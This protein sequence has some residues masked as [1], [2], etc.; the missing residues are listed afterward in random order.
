MSVNLKDSTINPII[1]NVL[2]TLLLLCFSSGAIFAANQRALTE[3]IFKNDT[4]N[5]V[6]NVE[7]LIKTRDDANQVLK[8]AIDQMYEQKNG[9]DSFCALSKQV[10]LVR[11]ALAKGANFS[12]IYI[13]KL[14]NLPSI[15]LAKIM[16]ENP[17]DPSNTFDK[18]KFISLITAVNCKRYNST[19]GSFDKNDDNSLL[20]QRNKLL[21]L[22]L[23]DKNSANKLLYIAINDLYETTKSIDLV[24]LAL[25]KGA[26]FSAVEGEVNW[27]SLPSIELAKIMLENPADPKNTLNKVKFMIAAVDCEQYNSAIDSLKKNDDNGLLE[28]KI[29]LLE[30]VLDN[31]D[32]ANELLKIAI[33]DSY[34]TPKSTALVKL[35]L[36]KGAQFSAVDKIYWNSLPSI[37]LVK[38]VL[39]NP[40]DPKNTI[41]PSKFLSLIVAISSLKRDNATGEY[42]IN[43]D[44]R[45]QKVELMAMALSKGAILDESSYDKDISFIRRSLAHKIYNFF[46][47]ETFSKGED[48]KWLDRCTHEVLGNA[49]EQIAKLHIISALIKNEILNSNNVRL[50]NNKII[51]AEPYMNLPDSTLETNEPYD[52]INSN[53]LSISA[54][55]FAYPYNNYTISHATDLI[56]WLDNLWDDNKILELVK[57]SGVDNHEAVFITLKLRYKAL[58]QLLSEP[59]KTKLYQFDIEKYKKQLQQ[60]QNLTRDFTKTISYINQPEGSLPKI[61]Q[62]SEQMVLYYNESKAWLELNNYEFLLNGKESKQLVTMFVGKSANDIVNKDSV[63]KKTI[64][65]FDPEAAF[66]FQDAIIK[67]WH[68]NSSTQIKANSLMDLAQAINTGYHALKY[69]FAITESQKADTI[70]T[71]INSV[72]DL[73]DFIDMSHKQYQEYF[74]KMRRLVT[75]EDIKS[76]EQLG[77]AA[78]YPNPIYLHKLAWYLRPQNMQYDTYSAYGLAED[79]GGDPEMLLEKNPPVPAEPNE[80]Y[81]IL[82]RLYSGKNYRRSPD[83]KINPDYNYTYSD[84]K[85]LRYIDFKPLPPVYVFRG[86]DRSLEEVNKDKGFDSAFV[87]CKA[88]P[89]D[90]DDYNDSDAEYLYSLCKKYILEAK[91]K[92]GNYDIEKIKEL[93]FIW[94]MHEKKMAIYTD[95]AYISASRRFITAQFYGNYAYALLTRKGIDVPNFLEKENDVNGYHYETI[96]PLH[97]DFKD[98]VGVR[99]N[100]CRPKQAIGPV[101]LQNDFDKKDSDNFW[102]LLQIFGGKSQVKPISMEQKIH[103]AQIFAAADDLYIKKENNCE[104]I[105]NAIQTEAI[106][107]KVLCQMHHGFSAITAEGVADLTLHT[108]IIIKDPNLR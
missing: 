18:V 103:I 61:S 40:A 26:Q 101:F 1:C 94:A 37:E 45:K 16:L 42:T 92:N 30:L 88:L 65:I 19:T 35:A 76:K 36:A 22:A 47:I 12:Y 62:E 29:K 77:F 82:K 86:E 70:Q 28:Q 11:L 75:M 105:L 83:I 84:I 17:A 24:K 23:D 49:L 67:Y 56:K 46:E 55:I 102:K 48:Y 41:A 14:A 57:S 31:K 58:K 90:P 5:V 108:P 71:A 51:V 100:S 32:S 91:A 63:V 93:D 27:S 60:E 68:N 54:S 4:H 59:S 107:S 33:N 15:E 34:H 13:S 7:K 52:L 2:F 98:V 89:E 43:A 66:V 74:K 104:K 20:E 50:E 3:A 97:A 6:D 85:S 8:M 64:E 53:M 38:I 72:Q 10:D 106:T 39:E 44:L 9:T 73:S 87:R 80:Y 78:Y 79:L 25:A 81:D 21:E 69:H 95:K 96:I 99:K